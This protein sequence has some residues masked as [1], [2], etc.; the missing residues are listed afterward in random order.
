MASVR[1]RGEV[2]CSIKFLLRRL[3]TRM[4]YS[5]IFILKSCLLPSDIYEM[6]NLMEIPLDM[7]TKVP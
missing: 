4:T 6:L 7:Q 1:K 2:K 5:V 3:L